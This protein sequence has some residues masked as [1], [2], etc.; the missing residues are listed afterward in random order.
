MGRAIYLSISNRRLNHSGTL[1]VHYE[2]YRLEHPAPAEFLTITARTRKVYVH[3]RPHLQNSE[4]L[5]PHN[6]RELILCLL[7][8]RRR[9]HIIL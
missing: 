7:L 8:S 9:K 5:C 2:M 6:N 3:S 1:V 4:N